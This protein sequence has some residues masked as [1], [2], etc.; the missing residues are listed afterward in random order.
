MHTLVSPVLQSPG[1]AG[2]M[3]LLVPSL[4]GLVPL[5]HALAATRSAPPPPQAGQDCW[6]QA[7]Q[8][9]QDPN[10]L[11]QRPNHLVHHGQ[12]WLQP[13]HELFTWQSF[14]F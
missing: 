14:L 1:L 12:T 6:S 8:D 4:P 11:L 10:H 2:A 9:P 5:Q 13:D 3:I 7:G